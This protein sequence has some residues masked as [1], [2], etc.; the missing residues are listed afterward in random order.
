MGL[1]MFFFMIFAILGVSLWDGKIYFRCYETEFPLQDGTWNLVPND[2]DLC[3][4][5]IR[6]CPA[7]TFCG[8][9][10]DLAAKGYKFKNPNLYIDADISNLNYGITNFDNVGSA[11]LTIF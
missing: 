6:D 4:P 7:G 1:A 5:G 3:S 9:R 11:F 10:L 2:Y 8:S